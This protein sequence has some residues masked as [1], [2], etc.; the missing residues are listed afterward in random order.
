MRQDRPKRR[1]VSLMELMIALALLGA[2]MISIGQVALRTSRYRRVSDQRRLAQREAA[3]VMELVYSGVETKESVRLTDEIKKAL[4]KSKLTVEV[5]AT[6]TAGEAAT[7]Y[8]VKI[9]WQDSSGRLV[10]PV[11]LVAWK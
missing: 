3:N 11:R 2:V 4:P 10:E 7:R 6:G 1:A 5:K 8:A 9:Q